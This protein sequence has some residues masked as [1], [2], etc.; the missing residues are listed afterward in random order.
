MTAY[1]T[2]EALRN[3]KLNFKSKIS[4]SKNAHAQAPSKIG[5]PIGAAMS[6]DLALRALLVKSANDV[7]VM[8]AE[9]VA[10]SEPAFIKRM[11]ETAKKLGMRRTRF[12]NP[13]GLPDDRQ[14][15]TA[16]DMGYLARGLIKDF[17][18]YKEYLALPYV[19]IGKRRLRNYNKLLR[20]FEGADG[21]KTGF[22]CASGFNLVASATR[23]GRQLVAVVL[24]GRTGSQRNARA[25]KLLEH[26]FKRY[27]WRSLF[28]KNIDKVTIQASLTEGA[29]NLRSTVCARKRVVRRCDVHFVAI[30]ACIG[31][32]F[33]RMQK[34]AAVGL[35]SC[36]EFN[37]QLVISKLRGRH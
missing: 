36:L 31:R 19:K 20:T 35:L 7:A 14:I 34:H 23:E 27:T 8:L 11:N 4:V 37:M 2:F 24:G 6:V 26:G 18:E 15:T 30:V 1:L 22:V 33:E 16:R 32:L 25:A 3:G 12:V 10:G 17:P 21:M 13:N 9:A 5:L 28:G 29:P